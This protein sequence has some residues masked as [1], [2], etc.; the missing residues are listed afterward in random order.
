MKRILNIFRTPIVKIYTIERYGFKPE[1]SKGT[2]EASGYD[3]KASLG[4]YVLYDSLNKKLTKNINNLDDDIILLPNHRLL[5]PTS[6]KLEL[7]KHLEAV[8]RPRSGISTKLGLNAILGTIDSDY[9][10]ELKIL[11]INTSSEPLYIEPNTR[12]AQLVFQEKTNIKLKNVDVLDTT[13]RG[14]KGFG[15]TGY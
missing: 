12:I 15:S 9:R 7:P 3:L 6:I 8:I 4:E 14:E 1:L 5:I 10:G 2:E 11:V 13:K